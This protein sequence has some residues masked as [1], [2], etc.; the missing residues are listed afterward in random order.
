M[1]RLPILK[2]ALASLAAGTV[3]SVLMLQIDW[4]GDAAATAA[5]PIDLLMDVTIVVSSYIF[6]LVCVALGY[7]LIKWR[8]QPGDEGDGLP[9]HGNTK[10]EVIWTVIPIIIVVALAGYSWAV[11]DDIENEDAD[12]ITVNVYSQQ[13]AW[14]FGY[15][16]SGNK[17]S[18]GELHVPLDRQ[19]DFQL[20]AQDVIHSFWVPEWRIKKDNVPGITTDAIVTPDEAGTYQ[21]ICTE[22]CGAGHSTMRATV[23]V[24]P[25]AEYQKWVN[26]LSQNVPESLLLTADQA[27]EIEKQIQE[28][29][30]GIE[31]TGVDET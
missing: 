12:R 15:P 11:L 23:V 17:W 22:L 25:E 28:K 6:A 27:L 4:F 16:E 8:V 2:L 14:T 7:A 29:E 19:V 24:E 30:D 31:G 18:E 1:T 20:H 13:F 9:I 5:G 21:L 3:I 26:G 10:L